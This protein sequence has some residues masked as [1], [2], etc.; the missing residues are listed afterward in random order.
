MA[1]AL[2]AL[3]MHQP[4]LAAKRSG[5]G[6]SSAC[7]SAAA[8]EAD[9]AIR[10]MTELMV[11]SSSCQDTIYAE[12]RLRNAD[13]I[14]GYQKAMIAHFH[15]TK[16]FDDWNTT[17]ANELS[18]KHS[19]IPTSQMCQQQAPLL[20]KA[21]TLDLAGFHAYAVAAATAAAAQYHKCGK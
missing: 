11:I 16:G 3:A 4:A 6:S 15:G 5:G 10:Y 12:F 9:Q 2:A 14:R 18:M 13:A 20:A 1:A 17:I 7:F 19:S 21:R 8:M